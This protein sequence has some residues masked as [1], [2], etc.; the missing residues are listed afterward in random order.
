MPHRITDKELRDLFKKYEDVLIA[1]TLLSLPSDEEIAKVY[2][3]PEFDLR[4]ELL[5]ADYV[6]RT[7]KPIRHIGRRVAI[8][9]I[10]ALIAASL[11]LVASAAAREWFFKVIS[12]IFPTHTQIDY[13]PA[14]SEQMELVFVPYAPTFLPD[15]YTAFD[16]PKIFS[17]TRRVTVRYENENGGYISFSQTFSGGLNIDTEDAETELLQVSGHDAFYIR[18]GDWKSL[19]WEAENARFL[20][21]VDDSSLDKDDIVAI[22]ESIAPVT[23]NE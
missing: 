19:N 6:Q 8:A 22:A 1:D 4:M 14:N 21:S 16:G 5:I 17:E 2:I 13:E 7:S 15:G 12:E 9:F 20:L 18:K 3:P 11:T 10:A 23:M